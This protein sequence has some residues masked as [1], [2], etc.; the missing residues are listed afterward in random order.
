MGEIFSRIFF[1]HQGTWEIHAIL[2]SM[3]QWLDI[4]K[5]LRLL[6]VSFNMFIVFKGVNIWALKVVAPKWDYSKSLIHRRGPWGHK[7]S[8]MTEQLNNTEGRSG[9]HCTFF[10]FLILLGTWLLKSI[11]D[12]VFHNLIFLLFCGH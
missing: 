5:K 4:L 2:W 9:I 1:L 6:I 11:L 8:D 3:L 7:G 10:Y 12:S